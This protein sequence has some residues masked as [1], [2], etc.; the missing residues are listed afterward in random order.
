MRLL[1]LL[2]AWVL[3]AVGCAVPLKQRM[4]FSL[5]A[6]ESMLAAFD[7]AERAAYQSK[8]VPALTEAKHKQISVVLAK[9]FRAHEKGAELL[10]AWRAGDPMPVEIP[11]ILSIADEAWTV[12]AQTFPQLQAHSAAEKRL[13]GTA[14]A[15]L[16][17]V[18]AM[19]KTTG[20]QL[21]AFAGGQ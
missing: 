9:A 12:L 11:Q 21:P 8:L 13:L 20:L 1:L 3:I 19:S 10:I 4:V 18:K 5:Q 2:I 6:S 16:E 17:R 7:D 14:W 15:W